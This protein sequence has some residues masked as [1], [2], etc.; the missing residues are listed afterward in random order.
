MQDR[1]PP[2]AHSRNGVTVVRPTGDMDLTARE[3]LRASLRCC[4]GDVVVDLSE[5][6]FLDASCLAVIVAERTRLTEH[7]GTL[8]LRE[9]HGIVS[10]VVAAAGLT[11]WITDDDGPTLRPA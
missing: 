9:P 7:G 3:E 6:A 5:V 11:T 1:L 4:T 10:I 2:L 8:R